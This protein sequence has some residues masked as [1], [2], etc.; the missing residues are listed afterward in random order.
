VDCRTRLLSIPLIFVACG[1]G[2]GSEPGAEA[3]ARVVGIYRDLQ[4]GVEIVGRPQQSPEGTVEI[5]YEGT[6]AMNLPVEGVAACTFAP[7]AGGSLELVTAVVD[8]EELQ[9]DAVEAAN[10]SVGDDR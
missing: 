5:H 4:G 8:G 1:G 10:R 3:C 6:G 2:A 9:P 7:G